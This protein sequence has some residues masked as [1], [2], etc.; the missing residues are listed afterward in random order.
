MLCS[1]LA[2]IPSLICKLKPIPKPLVI[3]FYDTFDGATIDTT[4]EEFFGQ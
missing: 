4:F 3:N 2:V 1:H